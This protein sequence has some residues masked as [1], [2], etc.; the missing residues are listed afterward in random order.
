MAKGGNGKAQANGH[1]NANENFANGMCDNGP[2]NE[3]AAKG[4][5]NA[6]EH[7]PFECSVVIDFDSGTNTQTYD[8]GYYVEG[9]YVQNGYTVSYHAYDYYYYYGIGNPIHDSNGSGDNEFG[10]NPDYYGYY[11]YAYM[12]ISADDGSSFSMDSFEV[13]YT[14]DGYSY[15]Y[16]DWV[17]FYTWEETSDGSNVWQDTG[18]Y[19]YDN[20]NWYWYENTYDYNT[21][22]YTYESGYTSDL[23]EVLALFD[24]QETLYVYVGGDYAIDDIEVSDVAMA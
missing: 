24:D 4:L 19:T 22:D 8:Y 13:T 20:V 16:Y 21:Y 9:T 6:L 11:D 23:D 18:A 3:N 5:E 17:Q 14:D 12:S 7:N 15:Y 1:D 2:P 10:S